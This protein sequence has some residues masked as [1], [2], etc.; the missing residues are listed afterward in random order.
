MS[1][2]S[3]GDYGRSS[4][5]D[6]L[7]D[8]KGLFVRLC[9]T[10]NDEG[11]PYFFGAAR[12]FKQNGVPYGERHFAVVKVRKSGSWGLPSVLWWPLDLHQMYNEQ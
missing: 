11:A 4:A 7:V 5:A 6:M 9:C 1:K 10:A 8:V 12:L 2:A 3:S